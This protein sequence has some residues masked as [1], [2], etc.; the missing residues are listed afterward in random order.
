VFSIR[1]H[2]RARK[3]HFRAIP[4]PIPCAVLKL[5]SADQPLLPEFL[6]F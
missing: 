3:G 2:L 5:Q 1:G 6:N 4:L